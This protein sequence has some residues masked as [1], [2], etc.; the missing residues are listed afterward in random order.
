MSMIDS[1]FI[2]IAIEG[3]AYIL[4]T[5]VDDLSCIVVLNERT[6]TETIPIKNNKII[7]SVHFAN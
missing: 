7:L 2:I 5:V 6:S 1:Y 4:A 3:A